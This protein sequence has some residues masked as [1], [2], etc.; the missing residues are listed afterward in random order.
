M[1]SK[2]SFDSLYYIFFYLCKGKTFPECRKVIFFY[3]YVPS[4]IVD[5]V[6][7]WEMSMDTYN[8]P[9]SWYLENNF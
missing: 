4:N 1:A 8:G 2:V 9:S 7:A 3:T 6:F 5:K